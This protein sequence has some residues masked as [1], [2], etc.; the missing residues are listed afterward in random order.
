[1]KVELYCRQQVVYIVV[2]NIHQHRR[3]FVRR[4]SPYAYASNRYSSFGI[5]QKPSPSPEKA[6]LQPFVTITYLMDHKTNPR[7][8]VR[9]RDTHSL[10]VVQME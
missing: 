8:R 10:T 9:P 6:E 5:S 3:L 2:N 1:M 7:V 4:C